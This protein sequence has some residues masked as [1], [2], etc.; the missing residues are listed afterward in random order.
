MAQ[1]PMDG[2]VALVEDERLYISV[3]ND[4][5]EEIPPLSFVTPIGMAYNGAVVVDGIQEDGDKMAYVTDGVAIP[6]QSFGR[7]TRDFP[8]PVTYDSGDG[9]PAAQSIEEWGPKAGWWAAK[10]GIAGWKLIGP[11]QAGMPTSGLTEDMALIEL[12]VCRTQ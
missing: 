6:D 9:T 5:G 7:A 8:C 2:A 12:E 4:S 11:Y 10:K 3:Y 1:I